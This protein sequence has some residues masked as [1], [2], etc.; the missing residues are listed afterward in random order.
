ML[1]D[2][3]GLLRLRFFVLVL[4]PDVSGEGFAQR[5][6]AVGGKF[7]PAVRAEFYFATVSY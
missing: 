5:G 1:L 6:F 7:F 4:V 3:G 2:S